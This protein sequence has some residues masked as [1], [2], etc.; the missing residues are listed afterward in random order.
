[1][2]ICSWTV[3]PNPNTSNSPKSHGITPKHAFSHS[4]NSLSLPSTVLWWEARSG[5]EPHSM[6]TSSTSHPSWPPFQGAILAVTSTAK[7]LAHYS[8][9]TEPIQKLRPG[10]FPNTFTITALHAV[11]LNAQQHIKVVNQ[12]QY[13][14]KVRES[15]WQLV[16][17]KAEI[18]S[19]G[20]HGSKSLCSFYPEKKIWKHVFSLPIHKGPGLQ[21]TETNSSWLQLQ[22][23]FFVVVLFFL[24]RSRD[25]EKTKPRKVFS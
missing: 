21:A 24:C 18:L 11:S 17:I 15:T 6:G 1:M 7:W 14:P 13:R 2:V 19:W 16:G 23:S 25:E 5:G 3:F 9:D 22:V 10:H 20:Q 12:R 8:N 4:Q